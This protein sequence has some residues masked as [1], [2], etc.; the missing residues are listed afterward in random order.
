MKS[1]IL[2]IS[3]FFITPL[4]ILEL[5]SATITHFSPNNTI[6]SKKTLLTKINI[7]STRYSPITNDSKNTNRQNTF[8]PR[9]SARTVLHPYL[10]FIG[11]SQEQIIPIT[12]KSSDKIIIGILGGSFAQQLSTN[13]QSK[14]I[15]SL[16]ASPNFQNKKI[17]LITLANPAWKQPQQSQA[18]NYY[19]NLGYEFD[20]IINL[21][22][23]NEVSISYNQNFPNNIRLDYPAHWVY[24]SHSNNLPQ[25]MHITQKISDYTQNITNLTET[26]NR[27]PFKNS[28][29]TLSFISFVNNFNT[30]KINQLNNQ[31]L[32]LS[33]RENSTSTTHYTSEDDFFRE[34]S[35]LW[36]Q[37][38]FIMNKVSLGNNIKYFHFLQPNQ[39]VPNSKPLSD[40]EKTLAYSTD[41]SVGYL[42]SVTKGYPLLIEKGKELVKQNLNFVDL[43]NIFFDSNQTYYTDPCCHLNQ[44]GYER[45]AEKIAQT[46]I[47]NN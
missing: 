26:A 43:T 15:S 38:S 4:L 36:A 11:D 3:L 34:A 25:T 24:Y 32:S 23:F 10:G 5:V 29:L 22:G 27:F 45:V 44:A 20:Y 16:Q 40:E 6:L 46:I 13:S 30:N 35:D 28:I 8:N 37:S 1:K 39:Y 21:D 14:L 42:H 9:Q 47:E 12:K 41:T 2:I 7:S 19:L 31:L 33:S 18:L 17:E